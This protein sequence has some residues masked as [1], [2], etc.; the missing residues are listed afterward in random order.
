[1]ASQEARPAGMEDRM[2][3]T[4][5]TADPPV[6]RS[7]GDF[8]LLDKLGEGAMGIVYRARQRSLDR[9][10]AVKVVHVDRLIFGEAFEAF[11]REALAAAALQHPGIVS[12]H[13]VGEEP[14]ISYFAMDYVRGRSLQEVLNGLRDRYNEKRRFERPDTA[15]AISS[16]YATWV[17][18]F[19]IA[20]ADALACAH[21]NRMVHRDIKPGNILVDERGQPRIADFGLA[22]TLHEGDPQKTQVAAGTPHYIAPEQISGGEVAIDPRLDVYSLGVVLYEMLTL[23]RPFEGKTTAEVLQ[24]IRHQEPTAVRALNPGVPR[25]LET[26]CHHAMEKD[27]ERRYP[28]AGEFRDDLQ[29]FLEGLPPIA[30]RAGPLLVGWRRARWAARRRPLVAVSTSAVLALAVGAAAALTLRGPPRPIEIEGIFH[31]PPEAARPVLLDARA[32]VQPKDI[33]GLKLNSKVPV[34][35]YA[36]SVSGGARREEQRLL[37][38]DPRDLA[39]LASKEQ[40]REGRWDLKLPRGKSF[41]ACSEV[42]ASPEGAMDGLLVFA[43]P[44]ALPPLEDWFNALAALSSASG[45]VGVAYEEALALFADGDARGG[46]LDNV[47]PSE[48]QRRVARLSLDEL[49]GRE[50]WTLDEVVRYERVFPIAALKPP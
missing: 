39:T 26:I 3:P 36:L 44:S 18:R 5:P 33:L 12:V 50:D 20:V 1:M 9:E 13:V 41:V 49:S 48:L 42:E 30:R 19:V 2:D 23:R 35:L 22:R 11:R 17:A 34:F 24:A 46:S 21:K 47:D 14:G 28:T 40:E 31:L 27:P 37:P 8:D 29:R 15:V 25:D 10:V 32:S 4:D 43:S 6:I 16:D 38:L 7:L 45:G